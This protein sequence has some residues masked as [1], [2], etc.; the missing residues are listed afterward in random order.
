MADLLDMSARTLVMHGRLVYIIPSMSDFD[1]RTDLPRHECLR[2]VH[3]CYQPL[4]TE[5]GRRMVTMEK[6]RDY[7][8][9]ERDKYLSETWVNGPESA[10]KCANIREKLMEAARKKPGYE[11]KAA[12]RKTKRIAKREAKKKAKLEST[13]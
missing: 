7:D 6:V 1:E 13:T 12:H 2:L 9:A 5:L 11:E 3:V 10:D 4:S 8:P